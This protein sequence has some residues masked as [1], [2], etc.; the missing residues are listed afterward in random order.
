MVSDVA[1]FGR[2]IGWL[3]AIVKALAEARAAPEEPLRKLRKAME[4]IAEIK[5]QVRKSA[6]NEASEALDRLEKEDRAGFRRFLERRL[7][8]FP[9]DADD[10]KTT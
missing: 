6:E 9:A 1:S 4:Q 8:S 7:Q 3:S 2:Q 10:S 5:E